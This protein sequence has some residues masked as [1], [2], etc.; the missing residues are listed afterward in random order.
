MSTT[1]KLRVAVVGAGILGSR[2]AR[3]FAEQPDCELIAVVDINSA[4]AEQVA[5]T[6]GARAF[7]DYEAMLHS[8]EVDAVAIATP[9]HLHCAPVVTALRAGKHV[10][11][12]KPLA[13][14]AQDSRDMVAAAASAKVVAMVNYS[15]RYVSDHV[16]IKRAI[17][18]GELGQPAFILSVKFDTRS[19]PTGMIAGW[20]AQ[21][22]PIYFMSS[23]DLDLVH[24]FLG[25][26]PI[27]VFAQEVR[28]TLEAQGIPVHDGLNA[29]I[30]FEGGVSANF[31][32]SW[33][34]PNTYPRI[35]DGYMQIIGSEGALTYHARTRTAELYNARGGQEVK[36]SGPHTADVVDGKITGA[37]TASL[38]HFVD[39]IREGREPDTSPR[40]VLPTAEVQ[41]AAIQ[42]LGSRQP[43]RLK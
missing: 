37:F 28:G 15:Q 32:S 42:S 18:S 36:F 38:R 43:V 17:E 20:A 33:I 14:T 16:W 19:V 31:H 39:C 27:D 10:F 9:D 21:T 23:H 41:A 13:T 7:T 40:R 29:L 1:E 12:E 5:Q 24:W 4:R 25:T 26:D 2:H 34:H 30:Q 3:V 35:A 6:H 22:S 11:V 8:V